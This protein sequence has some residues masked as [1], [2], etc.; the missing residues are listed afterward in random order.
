MLH[1]ESFNETN[2]VMNVGLV[3]LLPRYQ[4]NKYN[5]IFKKLG[6]EFWDINNT[7]S[8]WM[9]FRMSKHILLSHINQINNEGFTALHM[10]GLLFF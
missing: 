1:T 10:C 7:I 4:E 9:I 2:F 8:S 3:I 6:W 5:S